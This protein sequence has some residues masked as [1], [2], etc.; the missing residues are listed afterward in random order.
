MMAAAGVLNEGGLRQVPEKEL[1]VGHRVENTRGGEST[2]LAALK[3]EIRMVSATILPDH[4]PRT[5]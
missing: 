5:R 1:V 3:V 4:E 2:L